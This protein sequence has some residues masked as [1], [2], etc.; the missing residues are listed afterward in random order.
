M[1]IQSSISYKNEGG[2]LTKSEI[3][4][5]NLS[6]EADQIY[7]D[8]SDDVLSLIDKQLSSLE[9][10]DSDLKKRE[11]NKRDLI[12]GV[13]LIKGDSGVIDLPENYEDVVDRVSEEVIQERKLMESGNFV[14]SD[15]FKK[16]NE[17]SGNEVV[18]D[19]DGFNRTGK[20]INMVKKKLE[21]TLYSFKNFS[22]GQEIKIESGGEDNGEPEGG[23]R[24][25][26]IVKKIQK[27][28]ENDRALSMAE[29]EEKAVKSMIAKERAKRQRELKEI[30][31][32]SEILNRSVTSAKST[33]S[34]NSRLF[35]T[36][37]RDS[38]RKG[39][40][41]KR[42]FSKKKFKK[43]KLQPIKKLSKSHVQAPKNQTCNS[44]HHSRIK[45]AKNF[46]KKNIKSAFLS[47]H[48]K[49]INSLT[50]EQKVRYEKLKNEAEQISERPEMLE[51]IKIRDYYSVYGE[52]YEFLEKNGDVDAKEIEKKKSDLIVN[53][54]SKG[55]FKQKK[56][57]DGTM[58]VEYKRMKKNL[59]KL[60]EKIYVVI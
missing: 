21:S 33:Q 3:K 37:K 6:K 7:F 17:S 18:G 50:K 43:T 27:V 54:D 45:S 16:A 47:Q 5:Q 14:D 25:Q 35:M 55:V 9:D 19:L 49:F 30:E 51:E 34:N 22:K 36:Q 40:N 4:L 53:K 2:G 15:P 26:R 46:V 52:Y 57:D 56:V 59:G 38:G 42:K 41:M 48:E 31:E 39:R 58:D 20:I 23:L 44:K 24:D 13:K 8:S 60:D 32:N 11:E 28:M 10:L 1:S 12:E 29:K